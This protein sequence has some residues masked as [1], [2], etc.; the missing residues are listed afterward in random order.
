MPQNV[1]MFNEE[2][3][4]G[5]L[6]AFQMTTKR[7]AQKHPLRFPMQANETRKLLSWSYITLVMRK[8]FQFSLG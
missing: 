6:R 3:S 7:K 1:I 8:S 4:T 2:L 5:E